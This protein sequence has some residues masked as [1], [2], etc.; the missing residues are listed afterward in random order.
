MVDLSAPGRRLNKYRLQLSDRASS[1]GLRVVRECDAVVS[2]HGGRNCGR[3]NSFVGQSGVITRPVGGPRRRT[4]DALQR[5][6]N[7]RCV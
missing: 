2:R 4:R 3:S 7:R 5:E 1:R 6:D